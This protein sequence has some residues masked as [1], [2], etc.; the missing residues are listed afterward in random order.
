MARVLIPFW[1]L[2]S[3]KRAVRKLLLEPRNP[4]LAV[5]L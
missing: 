4:R 2:D 3:G 1:A 5:E